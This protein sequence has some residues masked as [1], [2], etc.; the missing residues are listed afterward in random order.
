[1]HKTTIGILKEEKPTETRIAGTPK[2]V[3]KY[4]QWGF[5]VIVESNAG[6][7]SGFNDADYIKVGATICAQPTDI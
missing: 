2:T 7:K 4:I 6:I 5:A 1:M 3:E